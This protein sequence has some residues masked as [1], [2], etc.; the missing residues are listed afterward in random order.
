MRLSLLF[1]LCA[2]IA[3]GFTGS[4]NKYPQDYFRAP[5]N[6]AMYL[7]GTFGELRPNHFHAGIDIKGKV[8]QSLYAVADGYVARIKIGANGYGKVLYIRH[9]N[10]YTSV[11]AHMNKFTPELEAYVKSKQYKK[12]SFEI[13]LFPTETQFQFKKGQKIGQ[14]GVTGR[15]FGPHLHFE[16]RSTG[17]E[18]PINPLLFGL[19]VADKRAPQMHQ[20][21]VYQLNDKR[22]TTDT[23]V[24]NLVKKGRGYGVK[25][26]TI[27]IGAW[28]AGFGLKVYD[29]MDGVSNWNGIYSLQMEKDDEPAYGF[30]MESFSFDE[31]RYLNAHL[32]YEALRKKKAYFNRCYALPGNELTIYNQQVNNGVIDLH[33]NKATKITMLAKDVKDNKIELTFWVKRKEVEIPPSPTYNY[34]LLQ[35]E[36]NLIE[37]Q[38]IRIYM[39]KGTLY[40]NLYLKYQ[41]SPDKSHD[42]YSSVHHLHHENIPVHKYYDLGIRPTSLPDNLRSKAFIA[43]CGKD[44]K[45]TNYGGEWKEDKLQ[46]RVR[47]LGD[48]C[49]MVDDIKPTITPISFQRSM[50]GFNKMSFK[51]KDNVATSGIARGLRYRATIDGKWILMEYDGKKDLLTHRFDSNLKAGEHQLR[52]VVTDDRGNEAVFERTFIR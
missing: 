14:M 17:S 47:S 36:K 22:E 21:K 25:G 18:K 4:T 29:L 11:Y 51:I 35:N 8:G 1:I 24:I 50:K 42:I 9:P 23:K 32:D 48:F 52:L 3:M 26:D 34:L 20:I 10:G 37:N 46:T 33:K 30:N 2:I 49:I 28:R 27:M 41:S 45:V 44:N 15:S 7:S 5:V 39:P 43:L 31:T 38:A 12:E 6:T 40:E 13:E 16:I 19:K